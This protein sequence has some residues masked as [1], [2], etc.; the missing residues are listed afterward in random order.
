MDVCGGQVIGSPGAG[1]MD[2][3]DHHVGPGN[4]I[5]VLCTTN[6]LNH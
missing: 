2:D 4:Q 5:W 1:V 3:C 6:A